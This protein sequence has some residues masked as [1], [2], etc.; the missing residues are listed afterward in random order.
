MKKKKSL[1]VGR[2][3]FTLIELLIVMSVIGILVAFLIPTF[4]KVQ[5][6]ARESGVK[7]VAHNV[8][9]AVESYNMVNET[10]PVATDIT[11][12][13]L[14]ENYLKTAEVMNNLPKNPFTGKPY[15]ETDLAGK[16]MYAFDIPANIYKI[17]AYNK[18]GLKQILELTN[19]D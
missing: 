6:R 5:D 15:E 17:T 19:M 18:S 2:H 8:Q 4:A 11:L 1:P 16:I 12:K 13:N 7:S 9:V 3:G 10:Y 14:F